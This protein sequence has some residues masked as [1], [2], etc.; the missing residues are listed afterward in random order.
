VHNLDAGERIALHAGELTE[1]AAIVHLRQ[2][3]R[4]MD[5]GLGGLLIGLHTTDQVPTI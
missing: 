1:L 5:C 4:E 2:R 3:R